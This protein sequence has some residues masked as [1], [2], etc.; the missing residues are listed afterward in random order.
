MAVQF[1]VAYSSHVSGFGVFAGG[2]YYCAQD[3]F[4]NALSDC[5]SSSFLLDVNQ[6]V[7]DTQSAASAGLIDP[8]S[9]LANMV[10]FLYSGTADYTVN[11]TVVQ[12]LQQQ[13]QL[14][15]VN[16]IT[17]QFTIN[18][19]HCI[20]T[21][22]Y[23]GGCSGTQSPFLNDW[24]EKNEIAFSV[25]LC[26]RSDCDDLPCSCFRFAVAAAADAVDTMELAQC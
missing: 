26:V 19:G 15:G 18:S 24:F 3:S 4:T 25:L 11:P 21:L 6:L 8:L 1:A 23:G 17:T 5:M 10:F 2:P 16:N 12:A 7:S 13:L 14:F 9:N 20:P 22:N